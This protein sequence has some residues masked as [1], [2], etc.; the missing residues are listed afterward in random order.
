MTAGLLAIIPVGLRVAFAIENKCV[1]FLPG[2]FSLSDGCLSCFFSLIYIPISTEDPNY[3]QEIKGEQEVQ[4][5]LGWCMQLNI[6]KYFL[7]LL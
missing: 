2:L 6:F 7:S 5:R 1:N 3:V 4:L